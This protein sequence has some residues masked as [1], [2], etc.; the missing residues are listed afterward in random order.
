MDRGNN[1]SETPHYPAPAV[2]VNY[3]LASV[4][5]GEI[6]MEIMNAAGEVVNKYSS[7]EG[8][9]GNGGRNMATGYYSSGGKATLTKVVGINRFD[10]DMTHMGAWSSNARRSYLDGPSVSPGTYTAKLTVG[11]KTMTQS[12]EVLI[13]PRVKETGTS[14][15]DLKEQEALSLKIVAL[16]TEAN[17]FLAEVKEEQKTAKNKKR[18]ALLAE[19]DAELVMQPGIYMQPM[20]TNQISYLGS[21]LKQADQKPGKDA[22]MRYDELKAKLASLKAKY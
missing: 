9:Q 4:P 10:W 22:Y 11:E 16:Q 8:A 7:A 15:A 5:T 6:T 2:T 12:F 19:L 13:D 18:V 20:L 3:H 21:M 14:L 1:E 17:K